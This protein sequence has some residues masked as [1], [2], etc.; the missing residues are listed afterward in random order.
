[1]PSKGV[2]NRFSK[3]LGAGR[4]LHL[5]A[6]DAFQARLTHSIWK[7][8]SHSNDVF[9]RET[10]LRRMKSFSPSQARA[11][12]KLLPAPMWATITRKLAIH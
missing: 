6:G 7:I 1:M 3:H 9:Y 12:S 4:G 11:Q 10:T 5:R 2:R 8:G